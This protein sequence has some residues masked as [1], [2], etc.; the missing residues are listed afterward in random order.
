MDA[1]SFVLGV[2]SAQLRGTTLRDLVYGNKVSWGPPA[3]AR[4]FFS[5]CASP[6]LFFVIIF[7]GVAP[8]LSRLH[9]CLSRWPSLV[10][11]MPPPPYAPQEERGR[12]LHPIWH[13]G[14]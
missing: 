14:D 6:S 11:V 3:R 7:L 10:N 1:I 2:R 4:L 9:R 12:T 5:F 13:H 8:R